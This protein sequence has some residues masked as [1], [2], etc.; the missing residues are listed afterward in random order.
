[1]LGGRTRKLQDI[2]VDAKVPR[3]ARQ[4]V[5]VLVGAGHI[6]WVGGVVRA[7]GARIAPGT[8][9]VVEGLFLRKI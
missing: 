2:L 7:H 4:K 3:E 8:R 5:P 6:L 1:M 9:R